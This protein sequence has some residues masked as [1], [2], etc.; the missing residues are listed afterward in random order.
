MRHVYKTGFNESVPSIGSPFHQ[1]SLNSSVSQHIK[2][3]RYWNFTIG[4]CHN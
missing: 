1:Q 4:I 3:T 2:D